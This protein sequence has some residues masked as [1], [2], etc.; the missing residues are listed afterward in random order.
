MKG[1]IWQV[2]FTSVLTGAMIFGL[3]LGEPLSVNSV[4]RR[5]VENS[6]ILLTGAIFFS[7]GLV[8]AVALTWLLPRLRSHLFRGGDSAFFKGIFLGPVGGMLL[9]LACLPGLGRVSVH[10]V[11]G[12][13]MLLFLSILVP[14]SI[15]GGLAG[16]HLSRH[17]RQ[18]ALVPILVSGAPAFGYLLLY[19]ISR[20]L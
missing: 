19:F 3:W 13:A 8:P 2:L 17:W 18:A 1:K 6:S 20:V 7:A 4:G 9:L 12:A 16:V 11:A 5:F 14:S 10:Q 15:L